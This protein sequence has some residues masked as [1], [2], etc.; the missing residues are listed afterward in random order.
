MSTQETNPGRAVRRTT[1]QV[2]IPAFLGLGV[3]LP[4]IM[5]VI[6]GS[7][8]ATM[9]PDAF[10][11]WLWGAAAAVTAVSALFAR[12]MAIPGVVKWTRKYLPVLAPDNDPPEH[13]AD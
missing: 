12:L 6:A 9:L 8:L 5:E 11:A 2:G 1:F 3:I 13:R 4:Q 10:Q 7:D